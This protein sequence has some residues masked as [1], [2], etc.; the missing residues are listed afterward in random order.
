MKS[1]FT[2]LMFVSTLSAQAADSLTTKVSSQ[3]SSIRALGMGNAFTAVADDYSLIFYNPAGFAKK[4]NNEVQITFAG[5]GF[6]PKTTA[7]MTDI[8]NAEKNTAGSDN[9]KAIAISNILEEYYGKS[10]G[11]KVQALEMFWVRK[12]WGIALIPLDLDIDMTF[13]RQLGPAIDLNVKGDTTVA[14]GYGTEW[15]QY[16]SVGATAKLTHRVAVDQTVAALE[17]ASDSNILSTKRFKE[18]NNIDFDLG[19]LWTPAWFGT[20]D[21]VET[22]KPEE[23]KPQAEETKPTAAAPAVVSPTAPVVAPTAETDEKSTTPETAPETAV[24]AEK[25]ALEIN[26]DVKTETAKPVVVETKIV[27]RDRLPLTLGVV[28]KNVLGGSFS[29][30]TLVNKDAVEAPK[31][32]PRVIDIGAAYKI[33]N[34]GD[35]EIRGMLDARNLLH[36]N[37]NTTNT[38][39]AGIEFDYSPSGWFKSQIRAGMNQ[40]YCTAGATL[41]LGVINID[42]ATYGEEMGTASNKIENRVYAAK[43]GMNF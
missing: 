22:Q 14:F 34:Y 1:V 43:V 20:E 25:P 19:A 17:L 5:A 11:G 35:L 9:D 26:N 28:L 4:K 41:L 6:S 13:N 40:M 39:H 23:R 10:L 42:F 24:T 30:S 15:N 21:V 12:G 29:K 16:V 2:L 8:E 31:N 7:L 37:A 32:I 36:P 33:A 18:G 38:L 27:K 3:Y